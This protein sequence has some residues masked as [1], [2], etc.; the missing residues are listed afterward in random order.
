MSLNS[1]KRKFQTSKTWKSLERDGIPVFCK[2]I[3]EDFYNL[4]K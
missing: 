2:T 3:K 1:Y 4:K